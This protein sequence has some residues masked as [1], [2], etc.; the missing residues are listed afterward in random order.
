LLHF[1][2]P[3]SLP[4]ADALR[5]GE[6]PEITEIMEITEITQVPRYGS[7]PRFRITGAL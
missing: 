7:W 5:R 6:I 4:A 2:L 3:S 1:A